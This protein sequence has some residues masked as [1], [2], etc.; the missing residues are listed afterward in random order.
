[1]DKS[2]AAS[3]FK[4]HPED[5]DKMTS[6]S[7]GNQLHWCKSKRGIIY[8]INSDVAKDARNKKGEV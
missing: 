1:M 7:G 3:Y 5:F 4:D 2:S 8:L 6:E